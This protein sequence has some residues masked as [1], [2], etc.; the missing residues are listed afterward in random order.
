MYLHLR[1]TLFVPRFVH[2]V[3]MHHI[4][5]YAY[6]HNILYAVIFMKGKDFYP[7]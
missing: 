7:A 1:M 4:T 5:H 3:F 2:D 6:V